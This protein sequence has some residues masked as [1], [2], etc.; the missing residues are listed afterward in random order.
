MDLLNVLEFDKITPPNT[1]ISTTDTDGSFLVHNLLSC[2]IRQ[3]H[4]IIFLTFS[5]KLSHYKS[6]QGKLGNSSILGQLIESGDYHFIDCMSIAKIAMS[7][8]YTKSNGNGETK[9]SNTFLD[10]VFTNVQKIAENFNLESNKC[11]V[12][13]DDLS[14]AHLMGAKDYNLIKF[15]NKIKMIN[16][17]VHLVVYFQCLNSNYIFLN[18]LA[19]TADLFIQVDKLQT[20]YSK[21]IDGQVFMFNKD[22]INFLIYNFFIFKMKIVNQ[23]T[24]ND[25]REQKYFY[26]INDKNVQ[27]QA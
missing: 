22:F 3:K 27:L 5:Q 15:L 25:K 8:N 17:N 21:Q 24:F 19:Y 7:K 14:I 10:D 6:I 12:F 26:K 1:I 2:C 16:E 13:V 11:F 9:D 4:K 23:Q 18:E 20:G